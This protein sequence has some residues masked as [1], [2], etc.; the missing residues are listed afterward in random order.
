MGHPPQCSV[1]ADFDSDSSSG[2][3]SAGGLGSFETEG[4]QRTLRL[5]PATTAIAVI[6]ILIPAL[7]SQLLVLRRLR[8]LDIAQVVWERWL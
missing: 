7:F 1:P 8:H 3:C 4:Y 5:T 6:G 2:S